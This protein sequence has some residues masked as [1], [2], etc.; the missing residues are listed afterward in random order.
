MLRFISQFVPVP[1]VFLPLHRHLGESGVYLVVAA[2]T[3]PI[4]NTVMLVLPYQVP[5]YTY[6]YTRGIPPCEY[7][8]LGE[9]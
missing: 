5:V 3:T 8:V 1:S 4:I 9:S 2:N 6:E 7:A